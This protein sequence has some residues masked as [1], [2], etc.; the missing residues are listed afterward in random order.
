MPLE[1]WPGALLPRCS[2]M[3]IGHAQS[4]I[5]E[6]RRAEVGEVPAPFVADDGGFALAWPSSTSATRRRSAARS[7][8]A[9]AALP[10]LLNKWYFDELYD[11]LF[12]RPAM[13]LGRFLW[14]KGDGWLIDGFGPTASR[15]ASRRHPR[16]VG[17]RPAISITTPSPC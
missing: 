4:S 7:P 3:H 6:G 12:V 1:F 15:R 17:C 13:W 2:T 14:K 16:V 10:F 9:P 11:F 8:R 5:L